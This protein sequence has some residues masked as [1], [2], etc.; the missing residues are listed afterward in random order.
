MDQP[1]PINEAKEAASNQV[2][3]NH[4]T[5]ENAVHD[6]KEMQAL[7]SDPVQDASFNG[8]STIQAPPS[9]TPAFTFD[10]QTVLSHLQ[11]FFESASTPVLTLVLSSAVALIAIVFGRVGLFIIGLLGGALGHAALQNDGGKSGLSTWMHNAKTA[12]DLESDSSKVC[13]QIKGIR[14]PY[15]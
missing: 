13:F 3:V 5:I 14:K 12:L 7:V 10:I 2:P 6:E 9:T 11:L 1:V 8:K 15:L 4:Y